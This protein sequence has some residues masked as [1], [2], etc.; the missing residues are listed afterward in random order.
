[1]AEHKKQPDLEAVG[2]HLPLDGFTILPNSLLY[3]LELTAYDK[4]VCAALLSFDWTVKGQ[5]KREVWPSQEGL[6][7]GLGMSKRCVID[8]L[9]RLEAAGY[10]AIDRARGRGHTNRYRLLSKILPPAKRDNGAGE[11]A[12]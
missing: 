8:S 7:R 9:A 4:L 11:D 5:R 1:M 6:S 3:A 12:Q 2:K 10:I